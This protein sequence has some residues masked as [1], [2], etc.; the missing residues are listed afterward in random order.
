MTNEFLSN[1]SYLNLRC[2]SFGFHLCNTVVAVGLFAIVSV[3]V[4]IAAVVGP[5]VPVNFAV[6][7]NVQA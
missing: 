3:A 6:G 2:H 4:V 7:K 5:V 1:W